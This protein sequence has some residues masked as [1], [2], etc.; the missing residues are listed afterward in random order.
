MNTLEI[1][2][3]RRLYGSGGIFN[4]ET[5]GA[6]VVPFDDLVISGLSKVANGDLSVTDTVIG[7]GPDA[8]VGYRGII[9]CYGNQLADRD[10]GYIM[11]S[12]LSVEHT[13]HT[14]KCYLPGTPLAAV[15]MDASAVA[16]HFNSRSRYM[17]EMK[18]NLMQAAEECG[19]YGM[20]LIAFAYPRGEREDGSDENFVELRNSDPMAYAELVCEAVDIAVR[21]K[22]HAIKTHYT[23]TSESFEYVVRA[24]QGRPIV[25]A[26]GPERSTRGAL[27]WAYDACQAGAKGTSYGRNTFNSTHPAKMVIAMRGIVHGGLNVDE[28]MFLAGFLEEDVRPLA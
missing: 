23:G 17:P 6:V 7:A 12:T 28:A 18:D 25:L 3:E 16:F 10:I 13:G 2:I 22:A 4:R 24:A 8:L 14:R 11:N 20:P 21:A 15:R 5:G 1:G 9:G 26:G 27:Q 19:K